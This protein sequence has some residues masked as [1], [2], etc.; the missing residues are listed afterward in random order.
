MHCGI[1]SKAVPVCGVEDLLFS[2]FSNTMI[3]CASVQEAVRDIVPQSI[4]SIYKRSPRCTIL[5]I[6]V[7]MGYPLVAPLGVPAV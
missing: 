3:F 1:E 4:K 7:Q 2:F 5:K 6:L